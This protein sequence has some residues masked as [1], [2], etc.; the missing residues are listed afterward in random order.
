MKKYNDIKVLSEIEHIRRRPGMYVG[1]DKNPTHLLEE[2][3]DNALDEASEGNC[4]IIKVSI[5]KDNF[6]VSDNGRGIPQTWNEKYKT[7]SPVLIAIK[8]FSGGKFDNQSYKISAGLHG[9]GLV[10]VNALSTKMTIDTRRDNKQFYVEFIDSV[11]SDPVMNKLKGHSGT[12]IRVYPKI[13][14]IDNTNDYGFESLS[15]NRLRIEKR[16][17]IAVT[18]I[19][20]LKI[21]LDGVVITPYD[22][23][24]IIGRNSQKETITKSTYINK[25]TSELME[26]VFGY[27]FKSTEFFAQGSV[28]LLSVNKG[29]HIRTAQ[30][31]ILNAWGR[32]LDRE[33]K[34][35][36]NKEDVLLGLRL[37]S[38]VNV[39]DPKYTSQT[40]TEL[41]GR[42]NSGVYADFINNMSDVVYKSLKKMDSN[43]IEA[44]I[45]KF[46]DHRSHLNKQTS[47][48]YMDEVIKLGNEGN[49]QRR[50][51][52][53]DS[54]LVDC[55]STSREG[56]ELYIAEG[57]SA[58]SSLLSKRDP[59]IHAILPLK[60]KPQN[61][62][63]RE[64]DNIIS[65]KEMCSL[66]N[67]LGCGILHKENPEALRYERIIIA[68]DADVDGLNIRAL[69]LGAL[70]HLTPKVVASGKVY[71]AESP[72]YGQKDNNNE[73]IPIFNKEDCDESKKFL[74]YKGL[75]SMNPDEIYASI[76]DP[77]KRRITQVGSDNINQ[78]C[79]VVGETSE[80]RDIL[81]R[82]GILMPDVSTDENVLYI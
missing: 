5:E 10:A 9:V 30:D 7:Y 12:S 65:N 34:S 44:L 52:Q 8:Q 46:K 36:L 21:Y 67:S 74:R 40:K 39:R 81:L 78:A 54:K 20:G 59:K 68:T 31:I 73:F 33:T 58:G 3:L 26:L 22:E 23:H 50:S 75:G 76:L 32:L 60:G 62:I 27:D 53:K 14:D 4:S 63:G 79:R 38:R 82:E 15:I 77:N 19:K 48:K 29:V 47:S 56:T 51:S 18:F 61:T 24:E 45:S 2:V 69:V 49:Q 35:Y 64:V 1:T 41:E 37:F 11:H 70:C 6:T 71:I 17:K 42:T 72:L 57:D 28:N 25:Q 55:T 80:K 16:L 13:K 66:I 43:I